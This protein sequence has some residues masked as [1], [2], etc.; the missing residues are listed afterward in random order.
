MREIL[1]ASQWRHR[2][3]GEVPAEAPCCQEPFEETEHVSS[4]SS[5]ASICETALWT[6][7]GWSTSK[8]GV[9]AEQGFP[10]IIFDWDDVLMPTTF[11]EFVEESRGHGSSFKLS[12]P[13]LAAARR[14]AMHVEML[15]R[16]SRELGRVAIVTMATK[17]WVTQSSARHMPYLDFETLTREL[18]IPVY[19]ALRYTSTLARHE[20]M[21]SA[22]MSCKQ[23][24]IAQCLQDFSVVGWSGEAP[25]NVVSVGDVRF[26]HEDFMELV[27]ELSTSGSIVTEPLFKAVKLMESPSVSQ[28]STQLRQLERCIEGM[29]FSDDGF[30]ISAT[31]PE[32]FEKVSERF[33]SAK[34]LGT[35]SL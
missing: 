20:M 15:L 35:V 18:D 24:A 7:S 16:T 29:V 19:E 12:A 11:F 26:E 33:V 31:D 4:D 5:S 9:A 6:S 34:R 25:L 27:S 10:A 22:E 14:H 21:Y 30:L 13:M 3:S 2:L 32:D 17:A 28:L 8:S 23:A 1:P